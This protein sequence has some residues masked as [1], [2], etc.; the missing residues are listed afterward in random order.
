MPDWIARANIEYFKKL[1]ETET[2]P[3]RRRVIERE[4]AEEERK[5]AALLK[6]QDVKKEG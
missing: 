5:L 1:L 3:E 6:K 4:L 2:D